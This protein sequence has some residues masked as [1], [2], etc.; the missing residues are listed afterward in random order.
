M[1]TFVKCTNRSAG[2]S[3]EVYINF[4]RVYSLAPDMAAGKEYVKV[5]FDNGKSAEILE[6]ITDLRAVLDLK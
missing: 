3:R 1:T 2:G 6:T 5:L 4:D